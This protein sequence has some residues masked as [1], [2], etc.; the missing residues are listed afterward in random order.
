MFPLVQ[1]V[2]S[3]DYLILSRASNVEFR[4]SSHLIRSGAQWD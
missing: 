2:D 4:I 1:D 3:G